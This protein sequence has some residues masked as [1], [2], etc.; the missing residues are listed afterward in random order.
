MPGGDRRAGRTAIGVSRA[1][2]DSACGACSSQSGSASGHRQVAKSSAP[3]GASASPCSRRLTSRSLR[4]SPRTR[5]RPS[6]RRP[7]R[8]P[9][10]RR[11]RP[12]AADRCRAWPATVVVEPGRTDSAPAKAP[13]TTPALGL[14]WA[15]PSTKAP[16]QARCARPPTRG[17][18][19]AAVATLLPRRQGQLARSSARAAASRTP[20]GFAPIADHRV[21]RVDRPVSGGA[22]APPAAPPRKAELPR[23]RSCSRRPTRRLRGTARGRPASSGRPTSVGASARAAARSP[24]LTWAASRLAARS[25]DRPPR[26]V[27]ITML[28]DA[29]RAWRRAAYGRRRV[30]TAVAAIAVP[31]NSA[32]AL[33]LGRQHRR[34]S[35]VASRPKPATG[36]QCA[37]SP[38]RRSSIQ[39]IA[40]ANA[41]RNRVHGEP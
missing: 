18:S 2:G 24:A 31:A 7:G 15:R 9:P 11:P 20:D 34:S 8:R 13:S 30:A 16:V 22:T 38:S 32:P 40:I 37:G 29:D 21:E 17:A 36:C 6:P 3:A 27:Q 35:A 14:G 1:V 41:I 19:S 26:V 39:P 5:P 12:L 10:E 4:R 28:R 33:R 25:S 23:R